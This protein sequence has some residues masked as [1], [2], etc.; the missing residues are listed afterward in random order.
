[1]AVAGPRTLVLLRH[2]KAEPA[3]DSGDVRRPLTARG[4]RQAAAV[5][6]QLA[7]L[8]GVDLALVSSALRTT[9]TYELLAHH[10]SVH[11][12]EV[13]DELYQAGPGDLLELLREVD[14][15]VRSVLVVGHEPTMSGTAFVLHDTRDD[16]ASQVS[17]G[18]PTATACV[19]DV[20]HPWAQL[21][22]S[23]AHLRQIVRPG[24]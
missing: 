23:G 7:A 11:S 10:L 14:G 8:G 18:I 1:M 21:D 13:R 19:L 6:P 22:R 16:L 9:E 15:D 4:R 3:G 20:P 17:L 24:E 12:H 2:A 5:G